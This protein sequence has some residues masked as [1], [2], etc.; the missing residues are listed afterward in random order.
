VTRAPLHYVGYDNATGYGIAAQNLVRAT[1]RLGERVVWMPHR[2]PWPA[3]KWQRQRARRVTSAAQRPPPRG[4]SVIHTVPEYYPCWYAR[5]R[6]AFGP[7]A[8]IWGHT[9]WE[10]DRLPGHWPALL[11]R[12]DGIIVPT[13]WNRSVFRASGVTTRIEVLPHVSQFEGKAPHGTA[14]ALPELA[15]LEGKLVFYAIGTWSA[16]KAPWLALAAFLT[17]FRPDDPAVFVLKT[18]PEDRTRLL[19]RHWTRGFR[20]RYPRSRDALDA[21]L[22]RALQPPAVIV[23]ER[24]LSDAEVAG[25]HARGDCYVSLSRGEGWGFG[26]YEAAWWGKPIIVERA[27]A[28]LEYLPPGDTDFVDCRPT[29]VQAPR[30]ETSFT[31][32]QRWAEADVAQAARLMR[33]MLDDPPAARARG[34]RIQCHVQ[35]HFSA[36][37]IAQRFLEIV[38][39]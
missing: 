10:T 34:K 3:P 30:H 28:P 37:A 36:A 1:R 13:E 8:P 17:A 19:P 15:G 18:D 27:G 38:G 22:S 39:S 11:N 32:E 2:I 4:V 21:I 6:D 5:H 12:M 31:M 29:P 14:A 16:R 25:L 24:H 33:A 7:H 9:V 35:K 26:I 20:W 23:I